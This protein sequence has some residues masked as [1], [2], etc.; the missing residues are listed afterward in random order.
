MEVTKKEGDADAIFDSI[1]GSGRFT[2]IFYCRVLAE[3]FYLFHAKFS[4]ICA[5]WGK[6][7]I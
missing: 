6:K 2:R 3:C 4:A 7:V 1:H 5:T